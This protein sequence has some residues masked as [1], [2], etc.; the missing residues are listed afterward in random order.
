MVKLGDT[1]TMG[2]DNMNTPDICIQCVI[3]KMTK[4]AQKKIP[5]D[6]QNE[7]IQDAKEQIIYYAENENPIELEAAWERVA[8]VYM[9]TNDPHEKEKKHFQESL[10]NLESQMEEVLTKTQELSDYIKFIL[11]GNIIDFSTMHQVD[12]NMVINT[13]KKTQ[14]ACLNDSLLIQLDNELMKAD[15]LVYLL[16]N[17]GEVIF[18]KIFIKYLNQKYPNL[19]ITAIASGSPISSDV[20]AEEAKEIYLDKYCRVISN[21]NDITG[22]YLPKCTEETLNAINMAD[23]ILSK[24]MA[25]FESLVGSGYNIYYIFLCKCNHYSDLLQVPLLSEI[26]INELSLDKSRII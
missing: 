19:N 17:V 4:F 18:D 20:T 15:N 25:N 26:F 12:M 23:L 21:G 6:R 2:R 11:A 24:G 8:R 10:L 16:D 1:K 9:N 14:Q 5:E 7:F 13:Q 3:N 22:T